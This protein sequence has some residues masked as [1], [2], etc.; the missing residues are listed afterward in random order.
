[1]EN[2][3]LRGSRGGSSGGQTA[4]EE[5]RVGVREGRWFWIGP[6]GEFGGAGGSGG[7]RGGNSG[8]RAALEGAEKRV[9]GGK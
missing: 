5:A 4:L 8:W 7:G 9:L 1:V 2:Y 6:G 3:A